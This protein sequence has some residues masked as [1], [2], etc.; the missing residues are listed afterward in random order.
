M[1]MISRICD[2][3]GRRFCPALTPLRSKAEE[4]GLLRILNNRPTH[5]ISYFVPRISYFFLFFLF[6]ACN[7]AKKSTTGIPARKPAA[8]TRPA[9]QP[10]RPEP[11]DTIRWTPAPATPIGS[12]PGQ[13]A[14]APYSGQQYRLAI[15]LPFLTDQSGPEGQP[16]PE[17][18][19]L[20]LQFYAGAS[21][22]L[23][24]LSAEENMNL[25]AD[26]LDTPVNDDAFRQ[27]FS[28]PRLGKAQV[29]IGPIRTS[30]V[31]LL[32]ERIKQTRQILVSPESPNM[33]LTAQN[34]DFIQT[35]P[36]L[37]AHCA[38][39]ARYVLQRHRPDA[40]TLV[41][42]QREADRLP[43]FQR[44]NAA[45]NKPFAELIVPDNTTSFDNIDLR[46]YLKSG[47][48]AV[49][50]LPTWA[51]QDFVMA[52]MRKLRASKGSAAVEVYGMPQ[53]MHFENIEPE[54]FTEL[55]VHV[56]SATFIRYDAEAVRAFRQLFYDTYGTI[57]DEDAFNG[58][59]V[60]LF[61]GRMLKKYGLSFPQ[62]L[63]T[64]EPFDGLQGMFQFAKVFSTASTAPTGDRLDQYDYLENI[65]VHILKY[66][67]YRFLP[68]D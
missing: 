36:S 62:R 13:T 16:V 31:G 27:L 45:G 33:D 44:T 21:L 17:K 41:C 57:P 14:P 50:I 53:W 19:R 15:L 6:F 68:A 60:T 54:F 38:A 25:Q 43:L 40:V 22:A 49:F 63:S 3:G 1:A 7:P 29:L 58:Y 67:N 20:A 39:I 12:I 42:K 2:I 18:S 59:D 52:F 55:H 35:S 24:K 4:P 65:F 48:T 46:P 47:R 10:A 8:T 61:T 11:M 51:S 26:V 34:P 66:Q 30:H 37:R 64:E 56:S 9:G 28:N 23:Q 5:P 32:A